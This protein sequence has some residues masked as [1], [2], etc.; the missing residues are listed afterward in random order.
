M[1]K[2]KYE[3]HVVPHF[4]DIFYWYSHDWSL[5]QIASELGIAK[6]TI[7]EYK[8]NHSAF[9]DLLKKAS[10][11]KPRYLANV[12]ERALRN[13]LEDREVEEVHQEQ[14]TGKDGKVTKQHVKKIK[15][16]IPADTTA[17]IF[18][19]KNADPER[20]NERQQIELSGEVST[21]NPLANFSDEELRKMIRDG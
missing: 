12:A 7:M 18:A 1:A 10:K 21:K 2:S 3:T 14:W 13:K 15:K 20:W 6:S 8:K 9:S 17:I 19:L 5:E 16:I 4:E 11:S